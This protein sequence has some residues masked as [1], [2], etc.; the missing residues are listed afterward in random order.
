MP[1]LSVIVIFIAFIGVG[2]IL[3]PHFDL[4]QIGA[5]ASLAAGFLVAVSYICIESLSKAE[6][7]FCTLFYFL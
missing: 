1:F 2:F 3:K 5:I 4:W 6:S 7:S